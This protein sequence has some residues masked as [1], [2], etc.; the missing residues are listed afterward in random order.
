MADLYE[1]NPF[2]SVQVDVPTTLHREIERFSQTGGKGSPDHRPFP[3][4]ID[5][6][7]LAVCI[8]AH[9]KLKPVEIKSNED[10]TTINLGLIFGSDPWRI[11]TLMLLAIAISGDESIVKEPSRMIKIAID[12]AVA[13]IPEVVSMLENGHSSPIWNLS[14]AICNISKE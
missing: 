13:G 6:W 4:M 14:E 11:H 5:M 10:T 9:R 7:F 3:R 12:L 2:Q 8:A 1:S